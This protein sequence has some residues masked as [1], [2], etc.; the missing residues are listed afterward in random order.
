M[1]KKLRRGDVVVMHHPF[2]F[3]FGN[4]GLV[5]GWAKGW[6]AHEE[7][8]R[9]KRGTYGRFWYIPIDEKDMEVIDHDPSLLKERTR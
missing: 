3:S 4:I 7:N 2:L 8:R 1:A 5:T 6:V 9:G